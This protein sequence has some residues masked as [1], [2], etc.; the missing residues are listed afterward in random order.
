MSEV[1]IV[2]SLTGKAPYDP[3]IATQHEFTDVIYVAFADKKLQFDDTVV[4]L[5]S[6][7]LAGCGKVDLVDITISGV[8]TAAD[9]TLAV[10]IT[11]TVSGMT[12]TQ[13]ALKSNGYYHVSND[14]TRGI[15]FRHTL[16]PEDTVSRQIQ[17]VS[18]MLPTMKLMVLRSE[19]VVLTLEIKLKVSGMRQKT[20]TLN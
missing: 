7:H 4:N 19:G 9:Q 16:V 8:C 13:V 12:I 11:S 14:Y 15:P 3:S 10:G 6:A 18:A 2:D 17:P 20:I 1:N 5:C